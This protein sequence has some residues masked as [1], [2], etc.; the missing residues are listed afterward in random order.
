[1]PYGYAIHIGAEPECTTG[2]HIKNLHFYRMYPGGGIIFS[3]T[4]DDP[5]KYYQ[6]GGSVKNC[7]F[8][9]IGWAAINLYDVP[10]TAG[11]IEM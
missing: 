2:V 1:M 6:G 3:G 11:S 4:G 7:T 8:E 9:T 10:D 5:K